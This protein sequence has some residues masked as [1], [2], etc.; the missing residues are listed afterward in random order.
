LEQTTWKANSCSTSLEISYPYGSLIWPT[1]KIYTYNFVRYIS[2]KTAAWKI[3]KLWGWHEDGTGQRLCP[4]VS[5]GSSSVE[6]SGSITGELVLWK[7]YYIIIITKFGFDSS[8]TLISITH[9][10]IWMLSGCRDYRMIISA[11]WIPHHMVIWCLQHLMRVSITMSTGEETCLFF[12]CFKCETQNSCYF[13]YISSLK[14]G[15]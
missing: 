14:N 13:N 6:S 1:C 2:W 8:I 10:W 11:W 5:F 7:I 15:T 3:E 12:M 9:I 4:M